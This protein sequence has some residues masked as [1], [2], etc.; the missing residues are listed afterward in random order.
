M[1]RGLT[2]AVGETRH[3]GT[4]VLRFGP[5]S[6]GVRTD[7]A[8]ERL[9]RNECAVLYNFVLQDEGIARTRPGLEK[10][11]EGADAAVYACERVRIGAEWFLV[12]TDVN[13]NLYTCQDGTLV[14]HATLDGP[15]QFVSFNGKL[16]IFDT[17]ALKEWGGP[18]DAPTVLVDAGTG[19]GGYAFDTTALGSGGT[20]IKLGAGHDPS[21]VL[22]FTAPEYG[23]PVSPIRAAAVLRAEGDLSWEAGTA[24]TAT[25]YRRLGSGI[26]PATDAEIGATDLADA[27]D[28]TAIFGEYGGM[29]AGAGT[30]IPGEPHYV[31]FAF[32]GGDA[33]NYVALDFTF[34]SAPGVSTWTYSGG[35]LMPTSLNLKCSLSPGPGM[36][37]ATAQAGI[38]HQNRLFVIEGTGGAHPGRIHYSAAGNPYDWSTADGGGWLEID[39]EIGGIIS[40]YGDVWI[41]GTYRDPFLGRLSGTSPA[42]YFMREQMQNV[43]GHWQG[44]VGVPNDVYFLHPNGVDSLQAVREYGDVQAVSATQRVADF[45]RSRFGPHFRMGYDPQTGVIMVKFADGTGEVLAVHT[46]QQSAQ[47]HGDRTLRSSPAAIWEFGVGRPSAFGNDEGS[48][49]VGT[50]DGSVYRLDVDRVDDDGSLPGYELASNFS[51]TVFEEMEAWKVHV[52]AF[53][54]DGGRFDLAF[55]TNHERT[56]MHSFRVNLETAGTPGNFFDREEVFFTF[57]ALQIRIVNLVPNAPVHIGPITVAARGIGGL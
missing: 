23:A 16:M 40:Y 2:R 42:S 35:A 14:H 12:V 8:A 11:C 20:G 56:E 24:V 13:G 30:M 37:G 17:G 26:D 54:L 46:L 36:G 21:A 33:D 4:Q 34:M 5:W 48:A 53:G 10:V 50:E 19:A 47:R 39:R 18:G 27:A 44:I 7:R 1:Y 38:V 6:G 45:I 43:S 55:H 52:D 57:R 3:G 15:S 22:A 51:T 41:F 32:G 25:L 28:L 29:F 49:L 9:A 31:L